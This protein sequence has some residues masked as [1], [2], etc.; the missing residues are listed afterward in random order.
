MKEI[1]VSLFGKG[2]YIDVQSAVDNAGDD[3]AVISGNLS[4]ADDFNMEV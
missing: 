3:G 1:T 2:D 4:L